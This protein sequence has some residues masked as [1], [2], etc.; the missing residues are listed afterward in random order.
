MGERMDNFGTVC[1]LCHSASEGYCEC[2]PQRVYLCRSCIAHHLK[3]SSP[4]PH[5]YQPLRVERCPSLTVNEN[6]SICNMTMA[7][8]ICCCQHIFT[9][10]CR[11]CATFHVSK[12]PAELHVMVPI[13]Y[14]ARLNQPG[15]L[16]GIIHKKMRLGQRKAELRV[17]SENMTR[18]MDEFNHKCTILIEQ[19][20]TYRDQ[21]LTT[22]SQAKDDLDNLI[23]AAEKEADECLYDD[24]PG[25]M[26]EMAALL[27]AENGDSL[28]DV[29][30]NYAL[31]FHPEGLYS[32]ILLNFEVPFQT[33]QGAVTQIPWLTNTS[34]RLYDPERSTW[35]S[36]WSFPKSFIDKYSSAAYLP[37]GQL[38][39]TGSNPATTEVIKLNPAD[40]TILHCSPLRVPRCGHGLIV[41]KGLAYVFGGMDLKSG[42]KISVRVENGR[43]DPLPDMGFQRQ[44]FNPAGHGGQIYLCGGGETNTI[45]VYDTLSERFTLLRD[46]ELPQKSDTF[47]TILKGTLIVFQKRRIFTWT[48]GSSKRPEIVKKSATGTE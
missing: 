22:I 33:P 29:F 21:L 28:Q 24:N 47:A 46:V 20:T 39:V 27:L 9:R 10:L 1:S 17:N 23:S 16:E 43:W 3:Q 8:S 35:K 2:Q 26:H 15:Y 19:L 25:H 32:A 34:L 37:D 5:S 45:E 12:A 48:I 31:H 6:C 40:C 7:D 4:S 41:W 36:P 44:F 18:C 13:K 42:E 11:G 14:M 38:L 30:F